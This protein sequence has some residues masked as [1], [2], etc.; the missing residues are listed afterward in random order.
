MKEYFKY[1]NGYVNINDE[2]LFLTNSGNWSE[3]HDLQEKSPKSIRKNNFRANKIYLYYFIVFI[4]IGFI[5][6]EILRDIKNK[7]FPFGIIF[8]VLA[9]FAYMKR[10]TGKRYK[11][12][13]SKITSFDISNDSVKIIFIN[14]NDVDDFEEIFKVEKKGLSIFEELNLQLKN[15]SF[16]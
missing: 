13:I 11:I 15:T 8:L 7:S 9:G 12:P 1:A 2:N 10:E 4:F 6:F 5:V 16:Q 3:T 14:A